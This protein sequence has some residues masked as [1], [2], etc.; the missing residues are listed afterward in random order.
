LLLRWDAALSVSVPGEAGL[1]AKTF[2]FGAETLELNLGDVPRST[3]SELAWT[4]ASFKAGLTPG[5]ALFCIGGK[6]LGLV[7]G[8][9]TAGDS[10][11]RLYILGFFLAKQC[12]SS[13]ITGRTGGLFCGINGLGILF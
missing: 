4:A 10:V 2:T 9:L 1:F 3:V 12:S 5:E 8:V 7:E 13:A 11:T 6:V